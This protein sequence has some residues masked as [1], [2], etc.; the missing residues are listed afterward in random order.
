[1]GTQRPENGGGIQGGRPPLLAHDFRRKSS[2]L[3]LL[4]RL[5]RER[6]GAVWRR[7]FPAPGNQAED[8]AS[9][10]ILRLILIGTKG[11]YSPRPSS[12]VPPQR[13][14]Q[15]ADNRACEPPVWARSKATYW[16]L[17]SFALGRFS[18]SETSPRRSSASFSRSISSPTVC[19]MASVT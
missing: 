2:V 10:T 3:Y 9:A 12:P 4:S 1:M 6:G 7:H 5:A 11:I 19:K 15:R 13:H 18:K 8:G 17:V 16:P 14:R